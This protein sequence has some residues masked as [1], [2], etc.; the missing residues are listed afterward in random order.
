LGRL[1]ELDLRQMHRP[2]SDAHRQ[3][4]RLA[5]AVVVAEVCLLSHGRPVRVAARVLAARLGDA[6][7]RVVASLIDNGV[8]RR[9]MMIRVGAG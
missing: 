9:V 1:Y 7:M 2:A 3:V 6:G 4:D 5:H 8:V